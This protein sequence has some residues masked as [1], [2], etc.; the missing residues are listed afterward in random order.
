MAD[1]YTVVGKT[2]GPVPATLPTTMLLL[3]AGATKRLRILR[4]EVT[5]L[6]ALAATGAAQARFTCGRPS[7]SGTGGAA[8]TPAPVDTSAPASIATALS[9]TTVWSAEPT[10]PAQYDADFGVN[11]YGGTFWV[12]PREFVIP[13]NGRFAVRVEADAAT[14][15]TQYEA[16]VTFE[17]G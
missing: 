11:Q 6:A 7:T 5:N 2:V 16:S 3:V 1:V 8:V 12:P 17:E 4:V 13:V 9:G 14:A 15:R 10:Q